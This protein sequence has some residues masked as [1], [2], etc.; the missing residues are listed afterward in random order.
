MISLQTS[1]CKTELASGY[2]SAIDGRYRLDQCEPFD[3]FED[4]YIHF[5]SIS[6]N[7][8]YEKS[9]FIDGTQ[10]QEFAGL[11]SSARRF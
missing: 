3:K 7:Y 9:H 10:D 4:L 6:R 8:R 2:S 5:H 11:G 1:S